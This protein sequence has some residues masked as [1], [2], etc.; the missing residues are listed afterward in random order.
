MPANLKAVFYFVLNKVAYYFDF[1]A[2]H[3]ITRQ[4]V[5]MSVTPLKRYSP[6]HQQRAISIVYDDRILAKRESNL[7][8]SVPNVK[9]I[10]QKKT[11]SYKANTPLP[12]VK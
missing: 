5:K 1:D 9:R 4:I 3:T 11:T 2:Q 7:K 12:P 6:L 8:P 10:P